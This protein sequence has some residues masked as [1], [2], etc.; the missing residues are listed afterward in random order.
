MTTTASHSFAKWRSTYAYCIF[1]QREDDQ[2]EQKKTELESNGFFLDP[3]YQ[4]DECEFYFL[5]ETPWNS[6]NDPSQLWTGVLNCVRE[7][8]DGN[9]FDSMRDTKIPRTEEEKQYKDLVVYWDGSM[10]DYSHYVNEVRPNI[11]KVPNWNFSHITEDET[12]VAQIRR[13]IEILLDDED[14][15]QLFLERLCYDC[16]PPYG[17]DVDIDE[18]QS[19]NSEMETL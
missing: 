1:L 13:V 7:Q 15:D 12:S 9:L 10:T 3:D 19:D 17:V 5:V 14:N 8:D 18:Q 11:R 6:V 2:F 4:D 16:D